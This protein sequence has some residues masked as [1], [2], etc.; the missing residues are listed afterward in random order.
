VGSFNLWLIVVLESMLGSRPKR[1]LNSLEGRQFS[2]IQVQE[3][4]P[5]TGKAHAFESIELTF[6]L[7]QAAVAIPANTAEGQFRKL[8]DESA[9][10]KSFI[11]SHCEEAG[12]PQNLL[13]R[14]TYEIIYAGRFW[15]STRLQR[16]INN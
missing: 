6:Q 16:I 3:I 10:C 1:P 8:F 4:Y 2:R 7:S 13:S 14:Y 15:L 12:Q 5:I 11:F 9:A